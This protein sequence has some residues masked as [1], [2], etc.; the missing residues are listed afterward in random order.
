MPGSPR[1]QAFLKRG[2]TECLKGLVRDK[3]VF[4]KGKQ[5]TSQQFLSECINTCM[6]AENAH[7][8]VFSEALFF[9]RATANRE[10]PKR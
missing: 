10:R 5:I 8:R 2:K 6:C 3:E 1:L 7:I 4:A 9:T